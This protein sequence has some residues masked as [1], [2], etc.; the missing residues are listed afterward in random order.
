M[1]TLIALAVALAPSP[2]GGCVGPNPEAGCKL[3]APPPDT[4]PAVKALER[5]L[6]KAATVK[7]L[8][9]GRLRARFHAPTA[10]TVTVRWT[11]ADGPV[12]KAARTFTGDSTSTITLKLTRHGRRVLR[13]DIRGFLTHTEFK[14]KDGS[15]LAGS[16]IDGEVTVRG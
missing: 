15:I 9:S 7:R 14:L 1:L 13:T 6:R 10:G 11:D 16:S 5:D 2:T 3:P 4:A 8:R 12:A